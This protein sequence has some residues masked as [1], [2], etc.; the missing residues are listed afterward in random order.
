M[1]LL[2]LRPDDSLPILQ[3]GF[4]DGLPEF[5]Y[6]PPGHPSYGAAD[7]CPGGL[8]RPTGYTCLS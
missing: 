4:V 1:P 2:P 5:S 6:L 3:D 7:F 8:N